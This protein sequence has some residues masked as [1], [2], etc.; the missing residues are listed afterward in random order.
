MGNKHLQVTSPQPVEITGLSH[1]G[2]GIAHIGGKLVFIANALPGEVVSF[3]Y[4]RKKT[5]YAEAKVVEIIKASPERITPKCQHFGYCG[6]C[7]VQHMA[8]NAQIAFKQ[9]VLLEQLLHFGNL[10]PKEIISP[11]MGEEWGYR[12]K[13]R[14]GVK[15]VIK[16]DAVLVGFR[17]KNSPYLA[18]L[19]RCEV[20]KP[21]VGSLIG[22]LKALI[23]SLNAYAHIAQI[24]VAIGDNKIALVVRN[25]IELTSEDIEKLRLFAKQHNLWVYLQPKGPASVY[26]IWPQDNNE[27][28]YYQLTIPQLTTQQLTNPFIT[29]HFHP[30]DFTQVNPSV[31]QQMLNKALELL[32]LQATDQ[33]LDLFCGLGNFTL[34]IARNCQQVVG[35]EGDKLMVERAG[36]NAKINTISNAYFYTANLMDSISHEAW[37]KQNYTKILLD[38]PRGGALEIIPQIA[39][40]KAQRIVYVSCNPATL[41]RDAGLLV[42]QYG[43]Q[44]A[45]AGV[46]N[47]FPQTSHVESIALF[48][49]AG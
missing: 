17:E 42:N 46:I 45:K 11:I 40:L 10:R 4:T 29:Y 20:L 15:Y 35:I 37:A 32:D 27:L 13:A 39:G 38:P 36:Y 33:V 49:L 21:G 28:L 1:D 5:K 3:A 44:L 18:D 24:E 31:N 2:R 41:A 6:G 12:H 14:L 7:S 34:P 8:G 30:L 43:Y 47:M 48:T 26:K 23:L 16:K 25:L 9:D 19:K 22:E